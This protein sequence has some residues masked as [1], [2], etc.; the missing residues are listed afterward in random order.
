MRWLALN[1]VRQVAQVLLVADPLP[2]DHQ[3]GWNLRVVVWE[4]ADSGGPWTSAEGRPVESDLIFGCR[5]GDAVMQF[6]SES[7]SISSPNVWNMNVAIGSSK[8]KSS[9]LLSRLFVT[10]YTHLLLI[11]LWHEVPQIVWM[12]KKWIRMVPTYI[13]PICALAVPR[14]LYDLWL[15]LVHCFDVNRPL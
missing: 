2:N 12:L 15:W 7:T 5:S 1:G 13:T 10:L 14:G 4:K 8:I 11:H 3:A 9:K 6:V